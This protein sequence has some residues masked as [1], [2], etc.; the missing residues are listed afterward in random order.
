MKDGE[1][2]PFHGSSQTPNKL[3]VRTSLS[4]KKLQRNASIL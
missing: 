1:M 2:H 3:S 4:L